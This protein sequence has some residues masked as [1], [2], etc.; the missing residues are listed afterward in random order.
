MKTS[1]EQYNKEPVVFCK[2][3]LS[4][5]VRISG[6]LDY[7]DDCG[8]TELGETDIHHWEELYEQKYGIK[9][10]NK[11]KNGRERQYLTYEPK[12]TDNNSKKET[13]L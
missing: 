11:R 13:D 5:K 2:H 12:G 7:C 8:C 1:K 6:N 3:C 9:Y 10:L 4:L